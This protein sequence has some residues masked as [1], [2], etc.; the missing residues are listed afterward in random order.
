MP[1]TLYFA[2]CQF[3]SPDIVFSELPKMLPKGFITS[4]LVNTLITG[5]FG[6]ITFKTS[7][8]IMRQILVTEIKAKI[9]WQSFKQVKNETIHLTTEDDTLALSQCSWNNGICSII[10]SMTS[11]LQQLPIW[12]QDFVNIITTTEISILN[13]RLSCNKFCIQT[14]LLREMLKISH[15]CLS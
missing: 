10:Q 9:K 7:V 11:L 15:I 6:I 13:V 12:I 14:R 5:I 8:H 3:S 4:V 2:V 1:M